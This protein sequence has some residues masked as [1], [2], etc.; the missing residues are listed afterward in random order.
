MGKGLFVTLFVFCINLSPAQDLVELENNSWNI[1]KGSIGNN[2]DV[3]LRLFFFDNGQI[4]GSYIVGNCEKKIR[5]IGEIKDK[6]MSLTQFTEGKM[7]GYFSGKFYTDSV[8][9]YIG[10]WSDSLRVT[11]VPF[12]IKL[13]DRLTGSFENPYDVCCA[14]TMDEAEDFMSS[15][16]TAL[17]SG[18]KQWVANHMIFPIK[19]R[20]QYKYLNIE[21]KQQLIDNFDG[22]FPKE[23]KIWLKKTA[24]PFNLWSNWQ[25][26]TDGCIWITNCRDPDGKGKDGFCIFSTA[27]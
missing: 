19:L 13:I 2:G 3:N 6:D 7:S 16:E 25:G 11:S 27:W 9:S 1:L 15:A 17:T 12:K 18:N 22:V 23:Y 20:L 24:C 14:G 10:T 4:K 26:I 5:L 21:N 8:T